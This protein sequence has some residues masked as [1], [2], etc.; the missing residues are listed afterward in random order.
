M[1]NSTPTSNKLT[2]VTIAITI[3]DVISMLNFRSSYKQSLGN[4][5]GHRI[6]RN[7][8]ALRLKTLT[9][10]ICST[11]RIKYKTVSYKM[12]LLQKIRAIFLYLLLHNVLK[13]GNLL[14]QRL[15]VAD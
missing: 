1:P 14:S 5:S 9:E 4:T 7:T 10:S 12:S 15:L 11:L 6:E 2:L 13:I 3:V 8:L